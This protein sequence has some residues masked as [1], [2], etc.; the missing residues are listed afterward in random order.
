[1]V[2]DPA[3]ALLGLAAALLL[4]SPAAAARRQRVRRLV[5]PG[6]RVRHRPRP[7][8][9]W[10]PLRRA[11]SLVGADTRRRAAA[12]GAGLGVALLVGGPAGVVAGLAAAGGSAWLLHRAR[13]SGGDPLAALQAALPVGCDLLAVCLAAGVPPGTALAAVAAA[14]PDPLGGQ[15][16]GVA[17][18][19]R[20][21]AEPA[22]AWAGAAPALQPLARVLVRAGESGSAVCPALRALAAELRSATAGRAQA[23]VQ[24]AGVWVLAPLGACFLPAFLCLGVVPLVLGIAGTVF[25]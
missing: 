5:G 14:V 12:A 13:V 7:S 15:L 20:L 23:R 18:L 1:M 4:W 6:G 16:H 19:Y 24:R 21:G 10:A 22:R 9:S 17:A 25:R 2:A 8:R 11:R 3:G